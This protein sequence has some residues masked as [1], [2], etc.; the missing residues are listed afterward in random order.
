MSGVSASADVFRA[1]ADPT[2]R[3]MLDLLRD[4]ERSVG[5]LHAPFR[6]T[7]PAISQH[8]RI[9]RQAGLV[10]ATRARRRKIYRLS[11]L[12]LRGLLDWA[13]PFKRFTD[14]SGHLWDL[15]KA[16]SSL[17]PGETSRS[18]SQPKRKAKKRRFHHGR[19]GS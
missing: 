6:M 9:L 18:P 4:A 14:P 3:A 12:P 19:Q 8:L 7:K 5:E 16:D 2:R 17:R 1:V 15:R 10:T 11:P 13:M